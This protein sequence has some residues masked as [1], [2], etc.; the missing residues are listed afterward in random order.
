[1]KA[2]T[3]SLFILTSFLFVLI[4]V[5]A[6]SYSYAAIVDKI[7]A[8]VNDEFITFSDYRLYLKREG[9]VEVEGVDE[10]ILKKMIEERLILKEAKNRG[11][12]STDA[13]IDE[14]IN[15]IARERALSRE[16]IIGLFNKEGK[17][18]YKDLLRDKIVSLKLIKEEVDSKVVINERD[19]EQFYNDHREYY[20]R[21]PEWVEIETLFIA[22]PPEASVTEITDLKLKTLKVLK[23]FKE[24]NDFEIVARRY[25]EFKRLGRFERGALLNPLNDVAFSLKEGQVSDP[26]W[27]VEGAYIIRVVRRSETTYQPLKDVKN[28]IYRILYDN[29][30]AEL[31]SDWLK[32]LWEG[33]SISIKD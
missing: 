22:M 25:G 18:D 12:T 21:E 26:I 8:T 16:E 31:L 33:A 30:R 20:V 28:Q 1:M 14:M 24:G 3:Y 4:S 7:L 29:K 13:E 23:M 11:I 10:G 2:G 15:E 19:V 5:A 32:R 17:K 9:Y 6:L 27:T